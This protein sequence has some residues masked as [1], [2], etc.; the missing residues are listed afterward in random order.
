MQHTAAAGF[1]LLE[2]IVTIA[3]LTTITI[4]VAVA[5][6]TTRRHQALGIAEQTL[7]MRIRGALATAVNEERTP[8]CRVEANTRAVPEQRCSDVGVYV[9]DE[10][11]ITFA[12]LTNDGMYTAID[13]FELNRVSFAGGVQAVTPVS[14]LFLGVP[15]DSTLLV[16]GLE[17][18]S[19]QIVLR[20]GQTMVPLNVYSYGHVS[21]D[22]GR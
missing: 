13:D 4:V 6:P 20:A 18:S 9:A 3:I 16:N 1:T 12:D 10:E 17:A 8:D 11:L 21:T 19:G 14:F 22:V 5:Y 7:Q 2:I 15:P